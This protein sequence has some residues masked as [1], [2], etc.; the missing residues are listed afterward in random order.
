MDESSKKERTMKARKD[1]NLTEETEV[2][3]GGD[4]DS[5]G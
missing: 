4:A 5:G 1:L 2:G 3:V